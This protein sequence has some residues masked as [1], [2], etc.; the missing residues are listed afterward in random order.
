MTLVRRVSRMTQLALFRDRIAL[1]RWSDLAEST[2]Q[3]AVVL[4]AE[5]I[6]GVRTSN[7]VRAPQE[8]GWRDE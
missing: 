4:L 1:P 6:R 2:R 8:Q 5:L 3:E 7:P